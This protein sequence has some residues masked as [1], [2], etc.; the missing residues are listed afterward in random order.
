M[1]Y[2]KAEALILEGKLIPV[3]T[4]IYDPITRKSNGTITPQAPVMISGSH[5]D[6][7]GWGEFELCLI[8]STDNSRIIEISNIHRLSDKNILLTLPYLEPG[9]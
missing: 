7:S 3:I 8:H 9:E 1:K 6:M 4:G 2:I 5:L